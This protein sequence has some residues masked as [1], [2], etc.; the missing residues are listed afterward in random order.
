MRIGAV[1]R[2]ATPEQARD[3][4]REHGA[5]ALY[6]AGATSLHFLT[7]A[8]QKLGKEAKRPIDKNLGKEAKRPIDKKVAILLDRLDLRGI[9]DDGRRYCIGAMT[10]LAELMNFR[11]QRWAFH[12]TVRRTATHQIRNIST[13]G[14]NICRVFPWCDL[15]V[16]LLALDAQMLLLGEE[17]YSL[18]ADDFF[19]SQPARRLA[20]GDLLLYVELPPLAAHMGFG[21]R[22]EVVTLSGFSLMTV[23][24][25]LCLE[26]GAISSARVAAGGALPFP[27]RLSQVEDLLVGRPAAPDTFVA[28]AEGVQGIP[29]KGREDW[30]D[31]YTL[32]VAKVAVHDALQR[33]LDFAQRRN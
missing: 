3:L 7:D 20:N 15:P 30:S 18:S 31:A 24:V 2:P 12:E 23:A 32:Q 27:R 14:G 25:R 26:Q 4:A 11:A 17:R 1:K 33:A 10:S 28:A 13:I 21:Y 29:W 9:S 6:L 5:Q 22:K 16:A 8:S 19:A